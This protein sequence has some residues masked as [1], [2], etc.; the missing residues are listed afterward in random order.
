MI[1]EELRAAF[2]RKVAEVPD[3]SSLVGRID[4][5]TRH[6]RRQRAA[7]QVT[8]AL[9]AVGLLALGIPSLMRQFGPGLGPDGQAATVP[10]KPLNILIAGTDQR[11]GQNNRGRADSIILAHVPADRSGVYL[12]TIAR[13]LWVDIDPYPPTGFAGAQ[14]KIDEAYADGGSELLRREVSELT[15]VSIDGT[16][17][18]N[19]PGFASLVDRLGG[20]HLCLDAPVSIWGTT[21]VYPAGCATRG[22]A[23][24][25]ELLIQRKTQPYGDLS[26]QQLNAQFLGE[27][28]RQV[29]HGSALADVGALRALYDGA[30]QDLE[31]DLGNIDPV[32]L[33]WELRSAL[34]NVQ[35]ALL[36]V[37]TTQNG[38]L[39]TFG[40]AP[41][42]SAL[43]EA[44]RSD[45][46]GSWIAAHKN[47]PLSWRASPT[48]P[49]TGRGVG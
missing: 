5:G 20:V 15:G 18:V 38:G 17:I 11:P 34:G 47:D 48:P 41:E 44:L 29:T 24:L 25:L 9:L 26:R 33:V 8:G 19:F 39:T 30:R 6:R 3:A 35:S 10:A 21:K 22:S 36:P 12:V 32:A 2:A 42:S 13:D 7:V 23:D 49:P 28:A 4:A 31:L 43:F 14:G 40:L 1:E 46:L 45:A 27:L 16:V 37:W